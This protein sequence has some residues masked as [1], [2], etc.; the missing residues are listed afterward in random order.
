MDE[1]FRQVESQ[2]PYENGPQILSSM[3]E[4]EMLG[5]MSTLP[6]Q[7]K[8]VIYNDHSALAGSMLGYKQ[9]ARSGA[10]PKR[11]RFT[12]Q[13]EAHKQLASYVS[14]KYGDASQE[15]RR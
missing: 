12:E 4:R 6:S 5:I 2:K 8:H 7:A 10:L 15:F 1:Y 9:L 14:K 11:S 3:P 13:I